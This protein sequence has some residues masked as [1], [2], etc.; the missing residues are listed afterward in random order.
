VVHHFHSFLIQRKVSSYV[1]S[2][3]QLL[4]PSFSTEE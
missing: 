3:F 1:F 2:L 4:R